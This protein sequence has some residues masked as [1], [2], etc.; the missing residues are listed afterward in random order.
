MIDTHY[1]SQAGMI[2]NSHNEYDTLKSVIVGTALNANWPEHCPDFRKQEKTTRW[3][4]TPLPSG[5]VDAGTVYEAEQDLDTLASI[6]QNFDVKVYRPDYYDYTE[7]D[8]FYGYCPRDRLLIIGD[9]VIVPNMAYRCRDQEI[10]TYSFIPNKHRMTVDDPD[11]R[12]DAANIL[13]HNKDIF[14]LYGDTANYEGVRWLSNRLTPLDYKIHILKDLPGVTHID[15]T[16][17]ILNDHTVIFNG[18][19]INKNNMPKY[20]KDWNC[21]FLKDSDITAIDFLDYPYASKWIGMNCLSIDP[22]TVIVDQHQK[23]LISKLEKQNFEVIPMELRH[24]RTLGGGF[25][26]VTLDLERTNGHR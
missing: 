17:S 2:I 7:T 24:A 14:Y 20:F 15:S 3:K 23:R 13:R 16:I 4:K 9:M 6:L 26:C 22:K 11:A 25:H 12:F 18:S 1:K 21:I 8:G 19:R 10:E 5:R